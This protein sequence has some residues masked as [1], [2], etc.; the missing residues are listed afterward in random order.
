MFT[1][2]LDDC[3]GWGLCL[4]VQMGF[5]SS[6]ACMVDVLSVGMRSDPSELP[7]DVQPVEKFV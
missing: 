3:L 5:A 7:E 6:T 2:C 1:W 4:S